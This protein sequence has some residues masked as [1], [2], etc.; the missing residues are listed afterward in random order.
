MIT[1]CPVILV[2]DT[3]DAETLLNKLNFYGIYAT[4][5]RQS[6]EQEADMHVPVALFHA[7]P[8]PDDVSVA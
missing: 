1:N 5:R 2:P 6:D 8:D 3:I 7:C 4:L